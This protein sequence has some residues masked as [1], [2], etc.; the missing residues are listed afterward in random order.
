MA[1]LPQWPGHAGVTAVSFR[2]FRLLSG[3]GVHLARGPSGR[4]EHNDERHGR[5]LLL[6]LPEVG[7]R[8]DD[9]QGDLCDGMKVTGLSQRVG[10]HCC[11]C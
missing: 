2:L 1:T 3:A 7:A 9:P 6:L 5:L 11:G 8:R 4:V 10:A